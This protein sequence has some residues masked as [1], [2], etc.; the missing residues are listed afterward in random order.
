VVHPAHD[1]VLL[2][3]EA[4]DAVGEQA[5]GAVVA[6][7]DRDLDPGARSVSAQARP[8]GPAPMMPTDSGRSSAGRI[9]FTQPSFQALSVM[10]RSTEPMVTV[11]WPACSMTQLP[12][13]RRSCGQMRPVNSG[14]L[15]AACAI[16]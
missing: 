5:P 4:R 15:L 14:K 6:V 1:H 12:S 11:P 16:S 10:K 8:A 9:G 3:L 13:Q 7:I 2:E